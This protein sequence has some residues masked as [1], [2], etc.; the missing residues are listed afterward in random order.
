MPKY[1][2]I[3]TFVKRKP[4]HQQY[5]NIYHF[6]LIKIVVL[7]Q[8]SLLN[9][10]WDGFISHEVF[11]SLQV[12]PSVFHEAR[13]PSHQQEVHETQTTSV[14]VF[15]TYQKGTRRLFAAAKR[16]LSPPGMEGIL[17]P[18]TKKQV[19]EKGKKPLHDEGPLEGQERKFILI[20]DDD[21]DLGSQSS[22][23]KEIIQEQEVDIHD[24]ALNLERA[25]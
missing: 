21:S 1:L 10:S 14:P 6:A 8:L 12:I 3:T 9:V 2:E 17:F 7:H 23:L 19:H 15:I 5:N 20:Q 24:L 4:P 25:K 22:K 11:T 16:V 13:G 18:S